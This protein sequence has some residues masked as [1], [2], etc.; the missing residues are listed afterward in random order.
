MLCGVGKRP[1]AL[2]SEHMPLELDLVPLGTVVV[3]VLLVLVGLRL[4]VQYAQ[5]RTR[6]RTAAI[7]ASVVPREKRRRST[8]EESTEDPTPD[9][10]GTKQA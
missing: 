10:T 6:L 2:H 4:T 5:R 7:L 1:H 3:A 8:V 9:V